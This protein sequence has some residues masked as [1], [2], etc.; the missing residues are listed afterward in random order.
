MNAD[1]DMIKLRDFSSV[2][3]RS[4]FVDVL[5]FNDYSHFD[6]IVSQYNSLK[7][8]TYLDLI[9]KVYSHISRDYRC[10][11]V[12]KNEL[13]KHLLKEY[14]AKDIVYFSEF[15]VGKSIADMVMFNGE[16]KVFEIKTEYDTTRRLDKQ[17]NDYKRFFD[18]CFIVIPDNKYD[19]YQNTIDSATGII[20]VSR[21]N[22]RIKLEKIRSAIPNKNYDVDVLMSCLRIE[23]YKNI[24][25][26][27]GVPLTGIPGYDLFSYCYSVISNADVSLVKK[28]FL[29]EIKKRRN[30]T[31]LLKNYPMSVRQMILSLNLSEKKTDILL[32]QLNTN[33]N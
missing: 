31:S 4:A 28:F 9:N 7:C 10:E 15:R 32:K 12:Y 1:Y 22:G 24:V 3:S 11:Y 18:K 5:N 6:W 13:I 2:F 21:K 27:L 16:S 8:S 14:G 26:S 29:Q 33:I 17:L 20:T 19:E 25:S 30:N 23:E